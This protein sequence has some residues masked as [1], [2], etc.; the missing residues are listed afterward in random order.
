MSIQ[1]RGTGVGNEVQVLARQ[2]SG[3]RKAGMVAESNEASDEV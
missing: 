3:V 2:S 1:F